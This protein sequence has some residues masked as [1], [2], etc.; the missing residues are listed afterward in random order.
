MT[1]QITFEPQGQF[2][3]LA[4]NY[5]ARAALS[6]ADQQGNILTIA[7]PPH[8]LEDLRLVADLLS[9]RVRAR[10]LRQQQDESEAL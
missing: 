1:T 9:G 2:A 5:G 7:M 6:M 8:M 4:T 10:D 3:V